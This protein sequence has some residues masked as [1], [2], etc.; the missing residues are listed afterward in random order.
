MSKS[1]LPL[2]IP[3][4]LAAAC[5][6]HPKDDALG[7]AP[8]GSDSTESM[9]RRSLDEDIRQRWGNPEVAA[10]WRVGPVRILTYLEPQRTPSR[11]QVGAVVLVSS[12]D[13]VVYGYFSGRYDG[14]APDSASSAAD[15][16]A[17]VARRS[18][19]PASYRVAEHTVYRGLR[20]FLITQGAAAG[21]IDLHGA[22]I[23]A[24]SQ[25]GGAVVVE[26]VSD[27]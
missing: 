23:V 4:F 24:T 9:S 14:A 16:I 26:Q 5:G 17:V 3:C 7:A 12:E 15:A 8:A 21:G 11:G 6:G 20:L 19:K 22:E 25:A 13:V 1:G 18:G 27:R 10:R 2:L